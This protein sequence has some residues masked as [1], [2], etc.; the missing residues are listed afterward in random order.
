MLLDSA[1]SADPPQSSGRTGAI[2]LRTRRR[3]CGSRRPWRSAGNVGSAALPAVGQLARGQPVEQRGA[4]GFAAA[5]GVEAGL[6]LGVQR[7]TA[8]PDL[9]GVGEHVV[10]DLEGPSGSKPSTVLVAATSASPSAEPWALPVFCASGAGQAMMRAQRDERRAVG[11]AARGLRERGGER[12]RRPRDSRR[13]GPAVDELDVPA[14]GLVAGGDVLGEGDRRCRPRWRCGC[15]PRRTTRLPR[16]WRPAMRRGLGGD[17]LLE[18]AV[19]G[20]A[21]DRVVERAAPGRGVRV[22]Q[23]A[24]VARGHRHADRVAE[25]LAERSGGRLDADG[26]AVLGVARRQRA[27]ACGRTGGRP[28]RGRSRTGRAGCRA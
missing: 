3:P 24:L 4:L 19:G 12:L 23:A 28:A 25:A 17:A 11:H 2:A 8:V 22:E 7:L 18:V 20:E 14:V 6:P 26:V 27:P 21:P 5:P 1:R 13:A 16:R 9:A 10:V 15:R